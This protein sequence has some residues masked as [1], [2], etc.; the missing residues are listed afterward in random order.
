MTKTIDNLQTAFAGECQATRKYRNFARKAEQEGKPGIAKLFRAAAAAETIHATNHFKAMDGIKSTAENLQVA[1]G[2][3]NYEVH[4]MYPPMLAE[5]EQVGDKRAINAF[6]W[7]LEVEKVHEGLYLKAAD[8][9]GAGKDAPMVDYYI[10]PVCGYTHEGPMTEKCP[11]C[12]TLPEKFV[13]AD[14]F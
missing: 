13:K 1:I 3:E 8:T 11:V 12:N 5:A 9:L 4:S 7:A 10:C 2:G 14:D 6:K